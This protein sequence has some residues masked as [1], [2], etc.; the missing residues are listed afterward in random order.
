MYI[1]K[2]QNKNKYPITGNSS[3]A[4]TILYIPDEKFAIQANKRLLGSI[5]V[6]TTT[7]TSRTDNSKDD[8]TTESHEDYT[9]S[10]N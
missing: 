9:H 10:V 8:E 2:I 4:E 6:C 1:N 5:L 3:E 7:N